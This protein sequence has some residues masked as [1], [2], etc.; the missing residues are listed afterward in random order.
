MVTLFVSAANHKGWFEFRLCPNNDVNQRVTQQCLDRYLLRLSD[1]SGTRL[2][3]T[4]SMYD[5]NTRLRLP[6][7]LTC[8]QCVLQWKYNT[9]TSCQQLRHLAASSHVILLPVGTSSCCQ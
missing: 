2:G 8:S 7:G 1:G 6:E 5:V 9:G 4:S 3:I